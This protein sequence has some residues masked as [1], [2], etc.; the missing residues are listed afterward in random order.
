MESEK[1]SFKISP[2]VLSTDI[3][4]LVYTAQTT[5]DLPANG[6]PTSS[7]PFTSITQNFSLYSGM[8]QILSGGTNGNSN[9]VII[10]V[11]S[12]IKIIMIIILRMIK[13]ISARQ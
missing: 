10:I 12:I 6:V 4:G 2:E 9:I 13:M 3:F 11:I 5:Y 8:T 7:T 1:L